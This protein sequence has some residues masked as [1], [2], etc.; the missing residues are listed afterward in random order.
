MCYHFWAIVVEVLPIRNM[1]KLKRCFVYDIM[2][3][4]HDTKS[5][6]HQNKGKRGKTKFAA[7]MEDAKPSITIAMA[8]G[9]VLPVYVSAKNY[10]M[11]V[12]VRTTPYLSKKSFALVKT[13]TRLWRR[14]YFRPL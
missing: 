4:T 2:D 5:S 10:H 7:T 14:V 11:Y 9:D 3:T 1:R 8:I 6:L 13:S 12:Q